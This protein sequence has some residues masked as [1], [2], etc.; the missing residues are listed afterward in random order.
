MSKD[1][2]RNFKNFNLLKCLKCGKREN[3]SRQK[4]D[5]PFSLKQ[6]LIKA[7]IKNSMDQVDI[8]IP[9]CK[10]CRKAFFRW[11]SAKIISELFVWIF[12]SLSL[13]SVFLTIFS[14][15]LQIPFPF[16]M[17]ILLLIGLLSIILGMIL[18]FILKNSKNNPSNYIKIEKS[19][20]NSIILV[21]SPSQSKWI[22]YNVFLGNA[23][24]EGMEINGD[25]I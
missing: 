22:P 19:N 13:V 11:N 24:L 25:T 2:L 23:Y 5:H 12:I 20:G 15:I 10:D 14:L 3:I 17:F 8:I 9:M 21:R 18:H 4:L 1:E 16:Y 7:V 6:S